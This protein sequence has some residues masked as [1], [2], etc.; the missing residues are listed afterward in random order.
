MRQGQ[1]NHNH[2]KRSRGR[3]RGGRPG[4]GGGGGGNPINR[5]YESN[6]PDVKVRGT[7]QTIAEKYMQLAR[8]AHSSGDIVM[9]ESYN[10]HAEHYLRILAA[11]QAYNQQ[12]M[13][14]QQQFRRPGNEDSAESF[15]ETGE[16]EASGEAESF[17]GNAGEPGAPQSEPT[18]TDGD[19]RQQRGREFEG[20]PRQQF[21]QSRG[22][23]DQRRQPRIEDEADGWDGP[24]PQFL[25]R[26][27]GGGGQPNGG[28]RQQRDRRPMREQRGPRGREDSQTSQEGE[29][30]AASSDS[31]SSTVN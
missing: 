25:R 11:A 12:H 7:A 29:T 20:R 31:D 10:Q 6:G 30:P 8:D 5:V 14:Q 18:A 1:H 21:D 23:G 9:A 13:A 2:N 15:E 17:G 16:V 4:G 28:D 22:G 19:T 3:G 24:Q 26:P 27:H